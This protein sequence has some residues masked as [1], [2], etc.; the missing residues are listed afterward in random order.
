VVGFVSLKNKKRTAEGAEHAE[1]LLKKERK[2]NF[3]L[4]VVLA[5]PQ[6]TRNGHET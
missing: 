5:T 1:I 3:H 4:F 2:T 6:K